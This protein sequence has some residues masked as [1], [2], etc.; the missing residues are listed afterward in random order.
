MQSV[1]GPTHEHG[2]TLDLVL[3]YGL[4]VFNLVVC[5]AFFSDDMPVLFEAAVCCHTVKPR[6]AA[7]RC[8]VI[9][10]STAAHLA[11]F[12]GRSA[13]FPSLCVRIQRLLTNGFSTPVELL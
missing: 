7:R 4:P 8:R 3:S 12:S 5:D 9:N 11:Q 1:I 10:P 13:S 6:A 2:H